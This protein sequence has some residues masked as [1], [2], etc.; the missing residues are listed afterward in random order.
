MHFQLSLDADVVVD[1]VVVFVVPVAVVVVV[2]K[3][4]VR[5]KYGFPGAAWR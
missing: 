3:L 2:T 1:D 5:P 4:N